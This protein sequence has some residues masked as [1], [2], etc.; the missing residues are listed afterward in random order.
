MLIAR[1][2]NDERVG[3][4]KPGVKPNNTNGTKSPSQ[5]N[6]APN[7]TNTLGVNNTFSDDDGRDDDPFSDDDP[8]NNDATSAK[9]GF[10]GT[11]GGTKDDDEGAAG[12]AAGAPYTNHGHD[13]G[14]LG[15]GMPRKGAVCEI[16]VDTGPGTTVRQDSDLIQTNDL[17]FAFA[18]YF[19]AAGC[20]MAD[21]EA[22]VSFVVNTT[23]PNPTPEDF[24][25]ITGCNADLVYLLSR[26]DEI[27]N[28]DA[29]TTRNAVQL[30]IKRDTGTESDQVCVS[31]MQGATDT[32]RWPAILHHDARVQWTHFTPVFLSLDPV[33]LGRRVA[34]LSVASATE[35]HGRN[36]ASYFPACNVVVPLVSDKIAGHKANLVTIN[37]TRVLLTGHVLER[38]FSGPHIR[39]ATA[40]SCIVVSSQR[41]GSMPELETLLLDVWVPSDSTVVAWDVVR[42]PVLKYATLCSSR[43]A[44]FE[45]DNIHDEPGRALRLLDA[46][47]AFRI[48]GTATVPL[49][50][51]A[52]DI[53]PDAPMHDDGALQ[54]SVKARLIGTRTVV[55]VRATPQQRQSAYIYIEHESDLNF[56]RHA[57]NLWESG[58]TYQNLRR[59]HEDGCM[60]DFIVSN[61]LSSPT[62]SRTLSW[63]SDITAET[64]V[65]SPI[66]AHALDVLPSECIVDAHGREHLRNC[67]TPTTLSFADRKVHE[68]GA[69]ATTYLA[70]ADDINRWSAP[71][72]PP[73]A[74]SAPVLPGT[75]RAFPTDTPVAAAMRQMLHLYDSTGS[76]SKPPRMYIVPL[77][78]EHGPGLYEKL[79]TDEAHI[80]TLLACVSTEALGMY[81]YEK[82]ILFNCSN[83]TTS[84]VKFPLCDPSWLACGLDCGFYRTKTGPPMPC[85]LQYAVVV[86]TNAHPYMP[87]GSVAPYKTKSS[88]VRKLLKN[89]TAHAKKQESGNVLTGNIMEILGIKDAPVSQSWF[90]WF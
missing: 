1:Q 16:D 40:Q 53:P 65:L 82:G 15:V 18:K 28:Y 9:D 49:D 48:T 77:S 56:T 14:Y 75:T 73:N 6:Y 5:N 79:R 86:S 20:S 57:A 12:K 72:N 78:P 71:L 30:T 76:T 2:F 39:T 81:K 32:R 3:H 84:I 33:L 19:V 44:V 43:R 13:S 11:N 38:L 70:H 54:G 58:N 46:F 80:N 8:L 47:D 62:W 67:D 74:P 66:I 87:P 26:F 10:V 27:D 4:G 35:A 55:S 24:A 23:A 59:L 34:T 21:A 50:A 25:C 63:I 7:H 22:F 83:N 52:V 69:F 45:A 17:L 36:C 41:I 68:L 29:E 37:L 51:F 42:T 31:V 61:H 89:L 64:I 60:D 85:N 88:V 90:S